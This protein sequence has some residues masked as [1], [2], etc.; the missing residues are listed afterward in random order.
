M[1]TDE[2]IALL[3][4]DTAP[5][6]RRGVS[7]RLGLAAVIALALAFGVL[8]VWLGMR[9]DLM[10]AMHTSAYWM[11]TLYTVGLALAGFA[12]VERLSRPGV[13]GKVGAGLLGACFVAILALAFM[14][15]MRTPSE[16]M[17][18]A[19]MG[20]SWRGCPWRILALSLPGLI[21]VL[22]AMRRFAP[23]HPALAGAGAGVFI[24][25]IAATVYGL[26]CQ[27]TAAPFVA[28]WYSLGIALSGLIGAIAGSRILRW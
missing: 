4:R 19:M 15:L 10:D 9:P 28:I 25:G 18:A 23:S 8:V 5:V 11:K 20:S 26:Y 27:E 2:L 17:S 13:S 1:K 22:A 14:Q 7:M 21:V 3:A 16:G 6:A 12:L 24:G